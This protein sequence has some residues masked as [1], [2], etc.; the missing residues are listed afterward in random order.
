MRTGSQPL[1]VMTKEWLQKCHEDHDS[2]NKV[3]K[4]VGFLPTRLLKI[5]AFRVTSDLDNR[6]VSY[7]ALSH[8]WGGHS[9]SL[10]SNNYNTLLSDVPIKY[11]PSNF[12]DAALITSNM[13]FS[14]LWIDSLCIIQD[15]PVDKVREIP[16][17]SEIYGHAI[18]TIAALAAENRNGG[19]FTSCYPLSL[20]PVLLRDGDYNIRDQ[21]WAEPE[22]SREDGLYKSARWLH[23]P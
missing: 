3:T 5:T 18:L 17:M 7:L 12:L 16:A 23:V 13:G 21:V 4:L 2:C 10:L 8:R 15:S 14:Y 20:V 11:L 1:Y 19:C 22:K 9:T 6:D